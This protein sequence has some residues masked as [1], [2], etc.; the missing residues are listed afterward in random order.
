MLSTGKPKRN[1]LID[2][3]RFLA[4]SWV[5]LFHFNEP[6]IYIDNWYRNFCKLGYLGVPVFFIISGY[7]ICIAEKH[8]KTPKEFIIRRFFRI[9][10]P[11]WFSLIVVVACA[12]AI[13][14]I[15]GTNS[16]PLPKTAGAVI[17]TFFLYTTPLSHF[18]KINWVYWTLPYELF[19]Y[20]ATF[21]ALT[22]PGKA[23]II[24]LLVLTAIAVVLPAQKEGVTF[25]FN[26]LPT[27][28]LGY[29]LYLII[30]KGENIWLSGLLFLLAVTGVYLKHPVC[31]YLLTSATVCVLILA[32]NWKPLKNNFFSR[33]GDYSYSVY[34]IHVPVAIYLLGFI[35][36]KQTVQQCIGLNIAVDLTL[37]AII[38]LLSKLMYQ[39]VELPSIK[40]GKKV[41]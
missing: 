13:K 30:N 24:L 2:L 33:L 3:L 34:L 23:K 31:S 8:S 20:L 26:E 16:T 37:L 1:Y 12:L 41:S 7:C 25:F 29:S 36:N 21:V 17:A 9:F 5:A 32:D 11:Y 22:L 39:K 10:P 18:P 28:I 27:F 6:V 15:T 38:V 14:V 40:L 4:A 19:F 35:K